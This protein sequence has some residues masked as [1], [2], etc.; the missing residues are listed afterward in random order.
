MKM[1]DFSVCVFVG[2]I[3]EV[4][5]SRGVPYSRG[6]IIFTYLFIERRLQLTNSTKLL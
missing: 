3:S 4:Y 5:R 6:R 1:I 2:S